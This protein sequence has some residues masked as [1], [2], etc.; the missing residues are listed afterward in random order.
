MS[1][2]GRILG[3]EGSL[4]IWRV[5]RPEP[6][7]SAKS[8][9]PKHVSVEIERRSMSSSNNR[10]VEIAFKSSVSLLAKMLGAGQGGIL[11]C[12]IRLDADDGDN[13]GTYWTMLGAGE[14]GSLKFSSK[15]KLPG[16]SVIAKPLV[17]VDT[18]IIPVSSSNTTNR[19]VEISTSKSELESMLGAGEGGNNNCESDNTLHEEVGS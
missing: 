11:K 10:G 17:L 3:A 9:C 5:Q 18:E 7:V 15:T 14:G 12:W 16:S 2:M 8:V 19:V 4:R 1:E 13:L 6:S